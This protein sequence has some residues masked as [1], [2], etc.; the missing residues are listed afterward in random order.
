MKLQE[1]CHKV[2]CIHKEKIVDLVLIMADMWAMSKGSFFVG[3][4][5]S[6]MSETV[7]DLRG[8]E[9]MHASN[10]CFLASRMRAGEL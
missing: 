3:G 6:T 9:S 8:Q 1:D 4:Y 7:C 2:L 10:Y 5:F